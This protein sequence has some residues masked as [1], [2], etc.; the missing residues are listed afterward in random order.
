MF[1]WAINLMKKTSLV[2][3]S[4][5]VLMMSFILIN[6]CKV[7]LNK[8]DYLRKVLGNLDQ[9]KSATYLSTGS[10]VA[11]GDTIMIRTIHF[12]T[13]EYTNP[14]DT[15]IGSSFAESQQIDNIKLDVFYDG[16]ALTYLDWN[17]KTIEID[18]FKTNTLP[19]RPIIPPF[20]NFT[21][22]IIRYAL[23]TNDSITIDLKDFGDSIKFSLFIPYKII[24]FHG[25]AYVRDHDYPLL[26][27]KEKFSRYDIWI[28]KSNA[29]PF[30]YRRNMPYNTSWLT[31]KNVKFDKNKIED[32]VVSKKFPSDFTRKIQGMQKTVKNNLLGK[33]APDWVL[34][35]FNNKGVAL[36]ELKSKVIMIQFTGIGCGPCHASIP[37]LKQLV[38]DYKDK[39]FEL[40]SIE[41]WSKDISIIK[42]YYNNNDLNYKFLISTDLVTKDYQ[43]ETVPAFYLL[44]KHRLIRKIIR[45]YGEETTSKEIKD[46]INELI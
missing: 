20:F 15:F 13:E 11:P 39:D 24:E 1:T 17:S 18:S 8:K 44:D 5:L 36:K 35:D 7:D 26:S 10:S 23:E 19:F 37:F 41:T 43:I 14:T 38:T 3:T 32:F 27:G 16:K 29:L 12:H 28:N 6:G 9:I 42:K 30:R 25:N 31:C 34:R 46:A 45:G 21:K 2:V 22:S 40:V 4:I 33:V